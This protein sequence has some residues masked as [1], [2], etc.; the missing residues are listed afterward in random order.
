MNTKAND[1]NCIAIC[2]GIKGMS[3]MS[4]GLG[5][6]V[7]R[8]CCMS[9]NGMEVRVLCRKDSAESPQCR[10][11]QMLGAKIC[12]VNYDNETTIQDAMRGCDACCCFLS[13]DG[14]REP[15]RCLARCAKKCG[16]KI[17]CPSEYGINTRMITDKE[18]P[19]YVKRE[20]QLYCEELKLPYCC[21]FNGNFSDFARTLLG[22]K[23]NTC[24]IVGRGDE[25]ISWTGLDCVCRFV[26]HCLRDMPMKE[27]ENKCH[28]IEGSRSSFNELVKFYNKR[29]AC[30]L[31]VEHME[32]KEALTRWKEDKDFV[33]YIRYECAQGN[34]VVEKEKNLSNG[35]WKSWKPATVEEYM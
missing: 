12:I 5:F 22:V 34:C 21:F 17:F 25:P 24:C 15:Q 3:T 18:S 19:L 20:M 30:D 16:V 14:L 32:P 13:G 28:A 23:G 29:H 33:S 35:L 11:L 2:G 26:C 27:L 9:G 8:E 31:K 4:A 6:M 1:L 10:E 7:A